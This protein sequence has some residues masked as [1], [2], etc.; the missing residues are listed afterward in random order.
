MQDEVIEI[1]SGTPW[2]AEM[3]RTLLQDSEIRSFLKNNLVNS[4]AYDPGLASGVKV[5][6]LSSDFNNAKAIVDG[7]YRNMKPLE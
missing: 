1:F 3:V 4:Y 5:M 2:E 6:I 7:Y